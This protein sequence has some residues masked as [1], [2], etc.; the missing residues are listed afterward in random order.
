M[1]GIA[2]WWAVRKPKGPTL[3]WEHGEMTYTHQ[4]AN[5]KTEERQVS[6]LVAARDILRCSIMHPSYR[7]GK[8]K[9]YGKLLPAG[10]S[11]KFKIPYFIEGE[12]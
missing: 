8:V 2:E 9:S 1:A 10:T 4:L 12:L 7:L 11:R 6:P 3:I 5:G